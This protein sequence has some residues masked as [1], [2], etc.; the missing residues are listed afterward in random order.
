MYILRKRQVYN[1]FAEITLIN[2]SN[3]ICFEFFLVFFFSVGHVNF[4]RLR[5]THA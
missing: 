4:L 2:M 3:K 5:A 1:Y